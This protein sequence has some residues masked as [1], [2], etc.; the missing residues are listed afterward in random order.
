MSDSIAI[1]SL[2]VSKSMQLKFASLRKKLSAKKGYKITANSF[3]DLI[4]ENWVEIEKI[5]MKPKK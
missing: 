4:G 2:Y 5:L 1:S 3:I